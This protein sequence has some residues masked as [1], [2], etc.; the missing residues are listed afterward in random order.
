LEQCEGADSAGAEPD[1]DWLS[2]EAI[3][4]DDIEQ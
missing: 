2:I 1:D 4:L 3:E